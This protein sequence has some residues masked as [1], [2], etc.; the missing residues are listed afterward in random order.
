MKKYKQLTS[1]Q[2]YQIYGLKQANLD[3]IQL[4]QKIDVAKS[5]IS[6]ECRQNKGNT[7]GGRNKGYL[8]STE[9]SIKQGI[10]IK[11]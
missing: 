9:N 11:T 7:T 6:R 1:G 2:R 4:V 5:T 10:Q 3:R 8:I